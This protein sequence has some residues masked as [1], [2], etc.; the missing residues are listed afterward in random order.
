MTRRPTDP[1]FCCCTPP[2]PVAGSDGVH[3]TRIL[4]TFPPRTLSANPYRSEELVFGREVDPLS[5]ASSAS[6]MGA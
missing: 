4:R 2:P 5:D 3:E 1:T 6:K